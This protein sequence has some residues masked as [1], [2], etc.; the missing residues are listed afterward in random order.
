MGRARGPRLARHPLAPSSEARRR[1]EP[2]HLDHHAAV[3]AEPDAVARAAPGRD[4]LRPRCD[5]AA[6][7]H[8]VD[9]GTRMGHVGR[10]AVREASEVGRVERR[11]Q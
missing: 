8:V 1:R 4:D 5:V 10:V 3:V 7:A 2:R 6:H 11:G 9:E